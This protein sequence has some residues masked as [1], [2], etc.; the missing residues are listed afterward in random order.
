MKTKG[1]IGS[2]TKK[3]GKG[4]YRFDVDENDQTIEKVEVGYEVEASTYLT[5]HG[6]FYTLLKGM[7]MIV[8][9]QVLILMMMVA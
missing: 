3:E 7:A 2:Y 1:Y 5:Q 8:V 6:Q 4:I 9:L